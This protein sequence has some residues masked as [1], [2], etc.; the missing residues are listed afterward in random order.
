[1]RY[2][3]ERFI[4]YRKAAIHFDIKQHSCE[5]IDTPSCPSK[6]HAKT[7]LQRRRLWRWPDSW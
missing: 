4:A 7:G 6:I 5:I 1:V 3:N 2:S